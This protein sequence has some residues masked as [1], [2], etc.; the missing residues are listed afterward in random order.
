MFEN[1]TMKFTLLDRIKETQK[2]DPEVQKQI[3]KVQKGKKSD[4]DLGT[5]GVLKFKIR[6]GVPKDK[7]LKKK[8]LDKTHHSKY[9]VHPRGNKMYQDLKSLYW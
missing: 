5:D 1:I 2:G 7:E 3:E 6:L 8:I 4:F 9:T